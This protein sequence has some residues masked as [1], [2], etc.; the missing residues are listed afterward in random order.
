[1]TVLVVIAIA[2]VSAIIDFTALTECTYR[3]DISICNRSDL[4]V[5]VTFPP[6]NS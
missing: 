5:I 6:F 4:T 2:L 3:F 1:M